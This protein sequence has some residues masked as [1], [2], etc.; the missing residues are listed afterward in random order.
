LEKH[1]VKSGRAKTITNC[2][3]FYFEKKSIKS[4]KSGGEDLVR[5]EKNR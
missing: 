4:G 1:A 3:H 5:V 2:P